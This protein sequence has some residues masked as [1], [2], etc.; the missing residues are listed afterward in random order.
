MK[1]RNKGFT[2]AEVV[3]TLSISIIV[4]V[5]IS[6]LIVMISKMSKRIEYENLCQT[7]YKQASELVLDYSNAY[8]INIFTVKSVADNQIVVTNGETDYRLSFD[9]SNGNLLAETFNYTTNTLDTLEKTFKNIVNIKFTAQD[10]IV[11][12]E[13]SFKNYPTYTN[14]IKFGA[15]E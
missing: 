4:V 11:L 5:L 3:I 14:I 13:Y 8:S 12:C 1:K 6:T 10:N 2:L 9:T 7:E 15:S